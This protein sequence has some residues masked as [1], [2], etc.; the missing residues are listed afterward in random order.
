MSLGK[1]LSAAQESFFKV[2]LGVFAVFYGLRLTWLSLNGSILQMLKLLL[3]AVLALMVGKLTGQLLGL[4]KLS[5]QLGRA[6]RE[7]FSAS[8]AGPQ[9][10]G[11]G[12]KT[13]A[14]LFC[15]A[16][17]GILGSIQDG[18]SAYYYPL[19]VKAVMDGL[20]AM[21]FVEFFGW[22]VI[23]AALPVLALQ[24]SITLLCMQ[25]LKPVLETHGLVDA[26]NATGGLVVFAVA[27]VILELKRI[28][29]ADYLP[30]L[31]FAPVI[32]WVLH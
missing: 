23:L 28:A 5:N 15:A 13:C 20:A 22:G 30:S 31:V 17:L 4:Q 1:P 21:G 26:T 3:I 27:L 24:G 32:A 29:L 19:G 10:A 9:R 14:G 6:A 18:L 7:R 11:D 25:Y 16:P 2:A 8:A 12:F